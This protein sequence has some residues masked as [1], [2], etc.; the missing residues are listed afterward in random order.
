MVKMLATVIELILLIIIDECLST[1]NL[2]NFRFIL[3][4]DGKDGEDVP[5]KRDVEEL[6]KLGFKC[7]NVTT[8]REGS[9]YS[10]EHKFC[11]TPAIQGSDGGDGGCGGSGGKSGDIHIL[12]L[13]N[14]SNILSF[15]QNGT[16]EFYH[17]SVTSTA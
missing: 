12:G 10:V 13:N 16:K 7:G 11:G 15:Q 2:T 17:N 5:E 3:G 9:D 8:V 4:V 14:K 6:T 1:L